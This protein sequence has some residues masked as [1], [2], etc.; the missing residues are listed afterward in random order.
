MAAALIITLYKM[1]LP[2]IAIANLLCF[3]SDH[4]HLAFKSQTIPCFRFR[5]FSITSFVQLSCV[6][7]HH[8]QRH[9]R[10]SRCTFC[11]F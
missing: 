8:F 1:P 9:L 11:S 3:V 6:N 4:F 10:F 2:L 7:S 5:I